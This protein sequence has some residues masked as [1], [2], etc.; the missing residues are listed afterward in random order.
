MSAQDFMRTISMGTGWTGD[1]ADQ[2]IADAKIADDCGID[3]LFVPETWGQDPFTLLA[4][5]AHETRRIKLGTSIVNIFGRS[6][7]VLAQHF[8]TLDQ[9]SAGRMILGLGTSGPKVVEHFHGVKFDKPFTRMREYVDVINLLLRGE[10]LVYSG[11]VLQLERGFQLQ[12]TPVRPHIPIWIASIN[13][14]SVKQT[15]E[16][17]DGWLPIFLP[18]SQWKEQLAVLYDAVQ[19]AGR[20]R[21]DVQVRC[22]YTVT[23]TERPERAADVRRMFAARYIARMGDF[24]YELFVRMGYRAEADAVRAAYARGGTEAANA[25]LPDSLVDQLG[26]AGGVEACCDALDEAADAGFSTLS[27]SV[28]ERDPQKRAAIFRKLVG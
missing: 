7:A 15:A 24:Y 18:K 20:K 17:A 3:A 22:P 14:K 25:A 12:L 27:V 10:K 9:L 5:L 16:I 21:E 19:S 8:A 23:V 6:A 28:A 2:I 4:L 1:N 26:F 11:K 13:P